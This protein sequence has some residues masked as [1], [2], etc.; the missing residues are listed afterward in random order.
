MLLVCEKCGYGC[1][2]YMLMN[3]FMEVE[4]GYVFLG[5]MVERG[6]EG[7]DAEE[8]EKEKLK[9]LYVESLSV[10]RESERSWWFYVVLS[11]KRWNEKC[12]LCRYDDEKWK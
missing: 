1:W 5:F 8:R 9:N 6:V 2:I 4:E 7:C 3:G 10:E 12:S 11:W